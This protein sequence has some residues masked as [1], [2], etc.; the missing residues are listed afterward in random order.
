MKKLLALVLVVSMVAVLG[1]AAFAAKGGFV[2]SPSVNPAPTIEEQEHSDDDCPGELVITPYNERDELDEEARETFEDAYDEIL[3]LSEDDDLYE[4]IEELAEEL[5]VPAEDL[6]VSDLFDV[7]YI[8]CDDT[9]GHS[10]SVT[11][12][13]DTFDNFAKL[14]YY[15]DGKWL[16]VD[17]TLGD[18]GM[19]SFSYDKTGT[20][21]VI[22]DTSEVESPVT[23]DNGFIVF[24]IVMMFVSAV[25]F[26]AVFVA[27]KKK[28][29]ARG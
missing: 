1:I 18:D 17:S 24:C 5:G 25:G 6:L 16:V 14:V 21:A 7:S 22:V 10:Y 12:D 4:I 8:N 3:N 15:E 27:A 20:F 23:G 19:V 13:S 29:A 9:E 2:Y 11:L 28:N 26:T